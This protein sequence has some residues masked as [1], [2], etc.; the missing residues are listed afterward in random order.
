MEVVGLHENLPTITNVV[1]SNS[2]DW[3]QLVR[4]PDTVYVRSTTIRRRSRLDVLELV[5][6]RA[7]SPGRVPRVLVK[8]R[9]STTVDSAV[10]ALAQQRPRLAVRGVRDDALLALEYSGLLALQSATQA[11]DASLRCVR[12]LAHFP[13]HGAM[14]LDYV[15]QPTLRS[16]LHALTMRQAAVGTRENLELSFRTCG[17][18]L[19]RFH[20]QEPSL[21]VVRRGDDAGERMQ[22]IQRYIDFLL[23]RLPNPVLLEPLAELAA[24]TC[25]PGPM[26]MSHG[27]LAPRNV[28]AWPDGHVAIFDPMPVWLA[29]AYEDVARFLV[30]LATMALQALTRGRALGERATGRYRL[31]F[32]AGYFGDEPVPVRA[33]QSYEAL[34][35]LDKWASATARLRG[36]GRHDK[37]LRSRYFG[38]QSAHVQREVGRLVLAAGL[39][40]PKI[41]RR[42]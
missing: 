8:T 13:E 32:L 24:G 28:F 9:L 22:L 36:P 18:V 40:S 30:E 17:Q 39:S 35:L 26:A 19:R 29:P 31:A 34:L 14:L 3:F 16:R 6:A 11:Q 21:P 41:G 2:A 7:S 12:P 37:T 25:D 23:P 42:V 5:G 20:E 27:D 33:L 10:S 4:P 1:L 15:E 38:M